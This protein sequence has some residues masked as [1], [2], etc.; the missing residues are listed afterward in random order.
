[1]HI[2]ATIIPI[3]LIILLGWW[4]HRRGFL[5]AEFMEPANRLVF[6]VAIPAIIF[7]SIAKSALREWFS[8]QVILITL[9]AAALAYGT[10]WLLCR[11]TRMPRFLA[12]T[13]IQSSG[14][15]NLGYIGLAVAFYYLGHNGF[16][17]ASVAAG[18]LMILQNLLSIMALQFYSRQSASVQHPLSVALKVLG[19]PVILSVIAGMAFSLLGLPVP[20]IMTR[21]LEIL[22]GLALPMA[23]LVI[24]GSLSP[25]CMKAYGWF[26]VAAVIIKLLWLPGLGWLMFHYLAIPKN[27]FLPALILLASPTATISYVMARQMQGDGDLAVAAISASTLA[28]ALTFIFWLQAAS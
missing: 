3:F 8:P 23:L 2:F 21:C 25:Q 7:Q 14:H 11:L 24:G 1:M 26:V 18:F 5:P 27:I 10:A 9:L 19:N 28:S 15:G 6:Y 4:V 22:G 12:G 20:L 17:Q 16:A 13:F